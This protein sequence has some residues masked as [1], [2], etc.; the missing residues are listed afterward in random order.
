[1]ETKKEMESGRPTWYGYV[2]ECVEDLWSINNKTGPTVEKVLSSPVA[3]GTIVSLDFMKEMIC[4]DT[5]CAGSGVKCIFTETISDK[6]VTRGAW[7][8]MLTHLKDGDSVYVWTWRCFVNTRRRDFILFDVIDYIRQVE[9]LGAHLVF[10]NEDWTSND[11]HD[12]FALRMLLI[13]EQY[14]FDKRTPTK[15]VAKTAGV[16]CPSSKA[17]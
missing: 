15:W 8:T 11:A 16:A 4:A 3:K 6:G 12:M 2:S 9:D 10:I 14:Q 1:M 13:T 17:E 7:N 5:G